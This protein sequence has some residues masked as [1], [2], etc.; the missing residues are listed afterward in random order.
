MAR[1]MISSSWLWTIRANGP[2]MLM[3]NKS[4]ISMETPVP[5]QMVIREMANDICTP[6]YATVLANELNYTEVDTLVVMVTT[7]VITAP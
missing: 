5:V 3:E 7:D 4:I 6:L 1:S 2:T